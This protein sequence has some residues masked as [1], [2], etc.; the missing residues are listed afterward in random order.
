[1][2]VQRIVFSGGEP[3]LVD[4]LT[5]AIHAAAILG[6]APTV[7]TSGISDD[8]LRPLS[9]DSAIELRRSGLNRFI[10]SLYS[11]RPDVHNSVTRYNSHGA[12]VAALSNARSAGAPVELHF[13]ALRRN[14]RDL[15]GVVETAATLNVEKISVLRFVPQ[16]RGAMIRDRLS[17]EE[18]R[19]LTQSIVSLRRQYPNLAIRTGSPLN[20][21]SICNTPCNAA[22]DVLLIDYAGNIF[23]CDA[24]KNVQYPNVAF[25]NV[26][27]HPLFDIWE[28][29]PFL[30]E[31][32]RRVVD[33]TGQTCTTCHLA[34]VCQSGCLAQKVIH[35][36]WNSPPSR[37]PDCLIQL[38]PDA[39]PF[40]D[41]G[42]PDLPLVCTTDDSR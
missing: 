17:A 42:Q 19:E 36:G 10:F 21:L 16:G 25:S 14:F 1:M 5:R 31:V 28:R 38:V 8:D 40:D 11:H 20:I 27:N 41:V 4:Y 12:T 9:L 22:Q 29:S 30:D 6:M 24:F 3:L 26:L 15:P 2:G 34:V 35:N 37:D 18:Y 23:P 13:V 32:R 39:Q 7:Y 33:S